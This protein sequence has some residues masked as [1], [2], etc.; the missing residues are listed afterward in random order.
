MHDP[1]CPFRIRLRAA[2][3]LGRKGL[4]RQFPLVYHRSSATLDK[5]LTTAKP[6]IFARPTNA[7]PACCWST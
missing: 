6:A 1:G 5:E 3:I 7:Y 4:L 2:C